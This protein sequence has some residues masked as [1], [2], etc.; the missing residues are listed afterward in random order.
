MGRRG[1]AEIDEISQEAQFMAG[2]YVQAVCAH[3]ML[4]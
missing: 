2:G 3:D 1:R 4:D